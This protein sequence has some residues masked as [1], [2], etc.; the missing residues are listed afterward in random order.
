MSSAR[1]PRHVKNNN[2]TDTSAASVEI[3]GTSTCILDD[4]NRSLDTAKSSRDELRNLLS[5]Q[6]QEDTAATIFTE[7]SHNGTILHGIDG[8]A[9]VFDEQGLLEPPFGQRQVSLS[10]DEHYDD[11][12]YEEDFYE[13]A[14]VSTGYDDEDLS[15]DSQESYESDMSSEQE[16]E[17]DGDLQRRHSSVIAIG[18]PAPNEEEESKHEEEQEQPKRF[19]TCDEVNQEAVSEAVALGM[20]ETEHDRKQKAKDT[21][22]H[23]MVARQ[24]ASNLNCTSTTTK[25]DAEV[26]RRMSL[27]ALEHVPRKLKEGERPRLASPVAAKT[28]LVSGESNVYGTRRTQEELL[29]DEEDL[30]AQAGIPVVMPGAFAMEGMDA[31]PGRQVTGYDSGFDEA[32]SETDDVELPRLRRPTEA[33]EAPPSEVAILELEG[34]LHQEPELVDCLA[35]IEDEV[36]PEEL[37]IP[38]KI[39]IVQASIFCGALVAIGIIVGVVVGLQGSS[40]STDTSDSTLVGWEMVGREPLRATQTGKDGSFFGSAVSLS[41]DGFRLAVASPGWDESPSQLDI[42]QVLVYDWNDENWEQVGQDLIG[43]GPRTTTTGGL[44]L[45]QTVALSQ[46]GSRVAFG[47]PDWNGGQV[48]I[49]QEPNAAENKWTFVGQNLTGPEG[50]NGRFG[51]SVAMS[52]TGA[53]VAV[54]SPFAANDNDEAAAGVVRVFQEA[55]NSTWSQLG[56]D[57]VGEGSFELNGWSVTLSNDGSLVAFGSPGSG[58]LG[59][60]TGA[61]RVYRLDNTIWTQLGRRIRGD[62]LQDKFGHSVSLSDNGLVLAVG[63]WEKPDANGG[64]Y[65]GHVRIYEYVERLKDW[66]QLGRDLV[67]SKSFDN[68]G[69]SVALSSDGMTVAVGSPR[70]NSVSGG[71]PPRGYI[72]VYNFDGIEWKKQG[73]SIRSA[74]DFENLGHSVSIS[75]NSSH[76]AGGAPAAGFDGKY[77]NVGKT[78]VFQPA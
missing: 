57:I 27:R 74:Q 10:E 63:G 52:F 36:P 15:Y 38:L 7:G 49:F 64:I 2:N 47:S 28:E 51:Y 50:E 1:Y 62:S 32:D 48:A 13:S 58:V 3:S 41:A 42:C 45:S 35:L 9:Q 25:Q 39:R 55:E 76:V 6:Q 53:T 40:S 19:K 33:A 22:R 70:S 8:Q 21:S 46:D 12:Y 18:I 61:V 69:Y 43:P 31:M 73:G 29:D 17:D 11:E 56:Q 59:D 37:E 72:D 44:S 14:S 54:G 68:F 60:F 4:E 67:G 77:N 23:K 26:K 20:A 78:S 65:V 16:E 5:T 66:T 75:A 30:E 24:K 34:E 71:I